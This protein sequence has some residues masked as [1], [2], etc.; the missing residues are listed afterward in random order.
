M[1]QAQQVRLRGPK[2]AK[3]PQTP[4]TDSAAL[5]NGKTA[6]EPWAGVT[7]QL[8]HAKKSDWDHSVAFAIITLLGF[9][10]RVWGISHP[11]QVVF[12]EVHFG[13]VR[14]AGPAAPRM[15]CMMLLHASRSST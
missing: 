1:S 10:T 5:L 9:L 7:G 13:K 6:E 12:D 3:R 4:I 15:M 11:D 14:G 8:K 2:D